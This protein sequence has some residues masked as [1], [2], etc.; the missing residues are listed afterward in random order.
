MGDRLEASTL[1]FPRGF[2]WGAATSPT[3]IEGHVQ[4]EWTDFVARDGSNCRISCD[5]YNRYREDIDW[6]KQLGVQSYRMGLEWSRLQS[7]PRGSL[8][9]K[10]LDRYFDQLD[11]LNEAG[12]TPMV[13]LHHF[14][15]PPW[16]NKT[17]G[18]TDRAAISLFL[19]YVSKLVKALQGRVRLWN[20]FNEPDT[21]AS[22]GY[23]I[24]QFPPLKR[25]RVDLFRKIV[26]HM[27]Q[28]HAKSC[29]I[30]RE[31]E[32]PQ[33][34]PEAGYS[35]NWTYFVPH[36][37][38]WPWDAALAG[39]IHSLLNAFV[40]EA[41]REAPATFLGVNYYGRIRFH[42]LRPLV[43][44]CGFS[45]E[46]LASIGV[47]CDDMLEHYPAGLE[48][49]LLELQQEYGLPLYLTEHGCASDDEDFRGLDLK[50]NLAALYRAMSLGAKVKGFYYWSLLDN[51][52]W[53]F[54]YA[55]KFGLVHVDFSDEKR[56]RR[57][58]PLGKVYSGICRHNVVPVGKC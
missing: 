8:D 50:E 23:I 43:P 33:G 16:L 42:H 29:E 39:Y 12:I 31:A 46:E 32:C 2:L 49:A 28:A 11:R 38:G 20:T 18:W 56:T 9:G 17:G 58:K 30:I 54:G 24:G 41:F 25:G 1:S 22:C 55:K 7:E 5:S 14:S 40:L 19:N 52:E 3:Q 48:T 37:K 34:E 47:S 27:G 44:T 21:Y 13:V 15:N 10:A 57:M 26:T 53:Q 45:R 51:F 4:N 35:K 36:G 6:L